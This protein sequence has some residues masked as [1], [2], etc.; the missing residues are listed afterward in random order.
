MRLVSA[1]YLTL[2]INDCNA[3]FQADYTIL[4][5]Q[6]VLNPREVLGL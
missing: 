3:L 6:K 4:E 2:N 1:N 5:K